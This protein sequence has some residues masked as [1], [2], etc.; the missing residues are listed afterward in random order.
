MLRW[1]APRDEKVPHGPWQ[2]EKLGEWQLVLRAWDLVDRRGDDREAEKAV[3][4]LTCLPMKREMKTLLL[5]TG[6]GSFKG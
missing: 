1:D 5:C 4:K 6:V 3:K 2:E